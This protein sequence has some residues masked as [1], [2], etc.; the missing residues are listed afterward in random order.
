MNTAKNFTTSHLRLNQIDILGAVILLSVFNLITGINESKTLTK[1][2]SCECKCK[3]DGRKCN[4]DQWWNNDKCRF[5]GIKRHECEKNY[6]WNPTAFNCG[7]GKYLAIIIHDSAIICDEGIDAGMDA[8]ADVEARLD[9]EDKLNNEAKSNDEE[10]KTVSKNF[11]KKI[12]LL[13]NKISIFYLLF[14]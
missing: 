7:N 2:I 3:I 9:E 14:Y 5:E 11:M 4:S 8:D 10:T 13:K 1:H 12:S 6:I